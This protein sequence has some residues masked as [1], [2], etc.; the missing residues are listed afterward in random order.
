VDAVIVALLLAVPIA[1]LAW[2]LAVCDEKADR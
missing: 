1:V 2:A